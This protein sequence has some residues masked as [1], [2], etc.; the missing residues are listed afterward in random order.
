[1]LIQLGSV[2]QEDEFEV[3]QQWVTTDLLGEED[4]GEGLARTL[5]VPDDAALVLALA[6]CLETLNGL[7]DCPELLVA[8][9]LL[10]RASAL[11]FVDGEVLDDVQEVLGCQQSLDQQLLGVGRRPQFLGVRGVGVLPFQVV[12][13]WGG[14][15]PDPCSI[16]IGGD[17]HLVVVE[18]FLAPF[19]V[20]WV[21]E[22]GVAA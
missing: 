12:L 1:M 21:S 10:D 17:H 18:E 6:W 15:G 4:H 13:H 3:P 20:A 9:D 5:G 2:R 7:L 16:P 22:V 19:C 11:G 14:D 8:G